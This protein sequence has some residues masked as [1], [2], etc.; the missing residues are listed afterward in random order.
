MF[1][2][3]DGHGGAKVLE[4][5]ATNLDKNVVDQVEKMGD[6]DIE[7][8]VKLGY[9]RTD[10]EF[11]KEGS[12]GGSCCVTVL[13]RKGELVVSNVGDCGA[14]ICRGGDGVAL[15]S[16][17]RPSREDEKNRIVALGGYVDCSCAGVWR[18]NESL[19]VFRGIGDEHLKQ[20]VTAEPETKVNN[21][22]AVDVVR[23][24]EASMDKLGALE[25]NSAVEQVLYVNMCL[26]IA[27]G[28]KH[29]VGLALEWSVDEQY[30]LEEGL[31]K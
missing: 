28:L 21:Q 29:E 18:I 8:A 19:A 13:I 31:A 14:I 27:S 12:H 2:V 22:E 24:N 4:F 25:N 26:I 9:L 16:D 10:S 30:K 15:T 20:W 17:H 3:Y 11:L 5:A 23:A 6:Q 1:G 7:A